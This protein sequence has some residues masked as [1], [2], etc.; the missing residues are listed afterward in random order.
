MGRAATEAAIAELEAL[1]RRRELTIGESWRLQKLI[2][3]Q[4]RYDYSRDRK[5]LSLVGEQVS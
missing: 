4:R 3:T 5:R 2:T 1:S